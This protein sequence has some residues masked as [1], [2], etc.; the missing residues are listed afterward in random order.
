M[1]LAIVSRREAGAPV[2]SDG[3]CSTWAVLAV[4]PRVE[5]PRGGSTLG[6]SRSSDQ[7]LFGH[8]GATRTI[9]TNSALIFANTL[10][11]RGNGGKVYVHIPFH[12]S[13]IAS[14]VHPIPSHPG[15]GDTKVCSL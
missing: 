5:V 10:G 14:I 12:E 1:P 6:S 7:T 13:D 15:N 2:D 3:I 8:H 4:F 11:T 9:S